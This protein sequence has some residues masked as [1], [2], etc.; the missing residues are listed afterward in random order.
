MSGPQGYDPTQPWTGSQPPSDQPAWGQPAPPDQATTEAPAWGGSA[1]PTQQYAAGGYQQPGYQQ[2]GY[3]QP[4]YQDPQYPA[5]DQYGAQPTAL[6]AA[7]PSYGQ[8]PGQYGQPQ[9]S[10]YGEQPQYGQTPGQFPP[11]YQGGDS[12]S[13]GSTKVILG[14][15]GAVAAV[16]II[17]VAILGFWV[18]GWWVKTELDVN[19]AQKGVQQVLSDE[20]NG[21]GAKNVEGVVSNK[22]AGNIEVEDG[23][24]FECDVSIDGTERKVTVT[25]QGDD[26]TYEV[27]RPR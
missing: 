19:A 4:G 2:P 3:Q 25:F 5:P 18:P 27:G 14:V 22:G 13:G 20:Q 7:V 9:Y 17:A 24:T 1:Y 6:G 21:Y 15:V 23:K 26:G 11:Q 16:V 10:P 8:T 12:G